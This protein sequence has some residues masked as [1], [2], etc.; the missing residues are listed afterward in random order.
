M[1]RGRSIRRTGWILAISGI[2]AATILLLVS[3]WLSRKNSNAFNTSVGWA[4]IASMTISA[5]GVI[6]IL[7]EKIGAV[8]SLSLARMT[9]VADAVAQETMRQ[10]GLLLAQLLSTDTLDSRAARSN[11]RVRKPSNPQR[12]RGKRTT[13]VREFSEITNFY[14]NET[15][16]RMVILGAAGSG[17]TVL[18]ATLT[19]GLL[20][21]RGM[22]SASQ[23]HNIPI[24]C[25][26]YLPSWDPA[27]H[28]LTEWLETQIADRFR[29]SRKIAAQLVDHGWVLPVLDGLD[30]MDSQEQAPRRSESAV[31]GIN[32]YIARTP[33]SHMVIVCRSGA[34]YY[35]RLARRV[36]DAE[37]ITIENLKSGQI[38]DYIQTQCLD[39]FSASSWVPIFNALK[40]RNSD[41]ILSALDT[42]WRLTAAAAFA[43]SGGDPAALLPTSAEMT[44]PSRHADYSDRIGRLLLETFITTR[45]SIHERRSSVP[46]TITQLR[47]VANLLTGEQGSGNGGKEI[48]LHRWWKMVDERKVLRT[49][50]LVV[51]TVMH[52][53][54]GLLGFVPLHVKGKGGLFLFLA[55]LANYF[56]IMMYSIHVSITRKGPIALRIGSL[57]APIR[58]VTTAI[59]FLISVA[60]GVVAGGAFGSL[61]GIGMGVAS[62]ASLTLVAAS[63]G[64]DP[65]DATR[66]MATLVNDRNFAV[67]MG[68]AIG[69]YATL[70]Y[71]T[72]YGL[73]IALTFASMCVL[74]V[75]F[76]SSYMRYLI[77]AYYG[78]MHRKLP[79]RFANF[80]DWCHS[81]GILRVSGIGYQF[82]HQELLDYLAAVPP[83]G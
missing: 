64:L 38:I 43:L 4:N 49:H 77:T 61:Y 14:L 82:R 83:D 53:S 63:T 23:G 27:T 58:M 65:S 40:G 16:R 35:E 73:A 72:L 69:A 10:N 44:E 81:A 32:D 57:R 48:I 68:I 78:G 28:D 13:A 42:P 20:K 31:S 3:A 79:F 71:V 22:V 39:E 55:I 36:R 45:I 54:F 21:Q 34:R 66:P 2:G 11:F 52:L 19:V 17:K 59:G 9:E 24:A 7:T 5:I 25:I 80:L 41:L 12:S 1:L 29:L 56:T 15:K 18:A 51:W 30:E 33:E 60:T 6:L 47:M 37:E 70:Y 67:V 74:G 8:T 75:T 26:F 50:A 46:V 62:A 76:S